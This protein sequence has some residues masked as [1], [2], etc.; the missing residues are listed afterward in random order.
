VG[1]STPK[2]QSKIDNPEKLAIYGTQDEEKLSK[3]TTKHVLY[4]TI[5]KQTQIVG[6]DPSYE[7]LEVKTNEHRFY[8][9]S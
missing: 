1:S 8:A 9:K 3:N 6:H 4:T 7:Q 2:G 5:R